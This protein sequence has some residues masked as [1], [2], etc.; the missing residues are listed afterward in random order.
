M[1]SKIKVLGDMAEYDRMRAA[2]DSLASREEKIAPLVLRLCDIGDEVC[3]RYLVFYKYL[4]EHPDEFG[5]SYIRKKYEEDIKPLEDK[6]DSLRRL[7]ADQCVG[8]VA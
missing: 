5:S 4:D 3:K 1:D 8:M 6:R 7:L 2:G